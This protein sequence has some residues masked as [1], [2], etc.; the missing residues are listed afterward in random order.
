M[1]KIK[2]GTILIT[3]EDVYMED[4]EDQGDLCLKKDKKYL[5]IDRDDTYFIINSEVSDYHRWN[6][7]RDGHFFKI[8]NERINKRIKIL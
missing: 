4:D 3:K 7:L 1:K 6:I 2:I 8:V 5:V